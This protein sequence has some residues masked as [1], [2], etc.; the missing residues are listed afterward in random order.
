MRAAARLLSTGSHLPGEPVPVERTEEVLGPIAGLPPRVAQRAGRL[1]AEVF[2]RSGVRQRHYAI[3]P[4][5]R[6]QTETN[7]S[8]LEKAARAALTA[9]E[10]DPASV[11]LLVTSGPMTDHSCPPTSALLQSRLGIASCLEIEIH[12]NCTGAPK[13]LAVA[14]DFLRTGRCRRALVT[15]SQLSSVFLRSE[16]FNGAQARLDHLALRWMLSD[17]SGAVLLEADDASR[18]GPRLLEAYVESLPEGK[19][20]GMLGGTLAAFAETEE[21]NGIGLL[22]S[23]HASGRHHVG[24]DIAAVGRHAG[25]QLVLGLARMLEEAGLSGSDVDHFLLGIPG[26]HFITEASGSLL[27]ERVGLDPS[28]LVLDVE[29]FGYCGGATM[30]VQLDRLVR[31]GRLLPGELAAAYLEESSL[32]MSGGCLVRG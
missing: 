24:Q 31:S 18:P 25:A 26:R 27:R 9:A 22:P 10:V 14:L 11:D 5:T 16:F 15:Y 23:L 6:R 29:D 8:M 30:F 32:W 2:S 12:S 28:E 13:G 20:P 1:V 7:V 3:D 17:G 19:E 4:A 21:L